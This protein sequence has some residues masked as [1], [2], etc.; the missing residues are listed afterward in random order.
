MAALLLVAGALGLPVNDLFRYGLL[1]VSTVV[2]LRGA[3][4]LLRERCLVAWLKARPQDHMERVLRQGDRRPMANRANAM[5]ELAGLTDQLLLR[6]KEL[7]SA[8][9]YTWEVSLLV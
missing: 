4:R 3:W 5:D 6:L 9:A 7:E 2:I 8:K 1:A